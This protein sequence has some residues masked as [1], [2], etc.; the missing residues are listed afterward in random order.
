MIDTLK[1]CT[2]CGLEK[3][4]DDFHV[5]VRSHDGRMAQ[6]KDCVN[7]RIRANYAEDPA[8]KIAKTQRR[9]SSVGTELCSIDECDGTALL[10]GMCQ[11]HYMREWHATRRDARNARN[12]ERLATDPEFR[13][14]RRKMAAM[15]ERK[16]RAQ[17]A[18]SAVSHISERDYANILAEYDNKCWICEQFIENL[19]WDHYHPLAKGGA[20]TIE[21]L[22]PACDLC[23]T[24]KSA[25]WPFTEE[26][27]ARI[28]EEVRAL[29]TPQEHTIPDLDG[30]EV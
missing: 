29:R 11:K 20:H 15:S 6:C 1:A 22:R 14:Y 28:A 12:K 27:R 8:T 23:N 7:A 5:R 17:K 21:N 18:G 19:H 9:F 24:R 13:E 30:L 2:K 3:S 26:M 16:R 25:N 4:I 10:K